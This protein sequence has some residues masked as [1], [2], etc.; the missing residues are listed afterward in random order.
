MVQVYVHFQD[1]EPPTAVTHYRSSLHPGLLCYQINGKIFTHLFQF[2][3]LT[4]NSKF[5]A[6]FNVTIPAS[7]HD[8]QSPGASTKLLT[9]EREGRRR[10]L[11]RLTLDPPCGCVSVRAR[12]RSLKRHA[13]TLR[14]TAMFKFTLL[15]S[16]PSLPILSCVLFLRTHHVYML[17]LY[18]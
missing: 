6:V 10:H 17:L 9:Q 13:L 12:A 15:S 1:Q 16:L 18:S 14:S 3:S 8:P 7:V 4:Y 2:N 5:P 11:A